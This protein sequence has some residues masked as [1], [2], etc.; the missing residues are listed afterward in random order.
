MIDLLKIYERDGYI[1]LKKAIN[2]K[3][4]KKLIKKT[5]IPILHKENIYLT[6]SETWVDEEGNKSDGELLAGPN[7]K[8]IIEKNNKHFRFSALFNS[9]KINKFINKIHSRNINNKKWQYNHLAKEGLGW[10]HLRYPF[11]NY[12][13][14][15]EDNV[16]YPNES[17]H[18]DGLDDNNEI[19]YNQSVVLLP[20]IN[21]VNKNEGGTA[22]MPGSHKL[23]ND[24]ILRYNY[25]SNKNT[26]DIIDKI[27]NNN[28]KNNKNKV[29]D[30]IGEQGD[31]LIMH[32]HLIHSS[33]YA[34]INSKV[35]ITFNLST[36]KL[37]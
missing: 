13:N 37:N 24:Y 28:K 17:L 18:L 16:K 29:I 5:L 15:K 12:K 8:H 10:I 7:N 6:K 36:E 30:V 31:I 21:I 14:K 20:F 4:C 34:D 19:S 9:K 23:I 26:Y 32:P 2:K 22:V 33:S 25:R 27:E 35:R 1:V 3:E 11:Y